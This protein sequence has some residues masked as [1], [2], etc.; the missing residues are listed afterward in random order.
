VRE[1]PLSTGKAD[2]LLF[3]ERKAVRVVEAKPEGVTPSE[4]AEQVAQ[5]S[6][7]LPDN[8][9]HVTFQLPFL[10]E[11]TDVETFFR[12]ERDPEPRSAFEGRW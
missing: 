8:I 5:Y 3:V 12:D 10:Y 4:V 2:Y 7:G 1:F 6:I 9:L 11:S